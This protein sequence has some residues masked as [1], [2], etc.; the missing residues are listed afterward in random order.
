MRKTALI[1]GACVN[2]GVA[3]V[4]KF[5]SEGYDIIFTGRN[6]ATVSEMEKSYRTQYP[7]VNISGYAL[8]SLS[9]DGSVNEQG[10]NEL[11]EKLEQNN[12]TIQVLVLN[13][14]DQGLNMKKVLYQ[15]S[16]IQPF[17]LLLHQIL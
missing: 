16:L 4:Q 11:F 3:I 2:T 10:V 13:A 5:A 14:A 6:Q 8:H 7:N 12:V 15:G 1:T 9:D 17:C